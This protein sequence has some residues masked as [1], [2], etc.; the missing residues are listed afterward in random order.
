[1]V[2]STI[3]DYWRIV[4]DFISYFLSVLFQ[5][6]GYRDKPVDVSLQIAVMKITR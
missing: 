1:V 2:A 4:L 6:I 5:N 3:L